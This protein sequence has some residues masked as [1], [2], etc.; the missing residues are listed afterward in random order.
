MVMNMIYLNLAVRE[1]WI[2]FWERV[3]KDQTA[4]IL[5]CPPSCFIINPMP[6]KS[7]FLCVCRTNVL[8]NTVVK[9]EIARDKQFLL[10]RQCFL[11]VWKTFCHLDDN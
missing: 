11:P 1:P 9:G 7:W 5:L 4:C 6:N 3:D 2:L 10:V 8:K